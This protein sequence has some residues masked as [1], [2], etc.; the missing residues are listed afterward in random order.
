MSEALHT[1][2]NEHRSMWQ[3]TVVLEELCKQI[4]LPEQRPDHAATIARFALAMMEA[5]AL[6]RP[7]IATYVGGVP[8]PRRLRQSEES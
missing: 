5:L 7:V 2:S 3:L 8:E 1:I 4:G 6:A